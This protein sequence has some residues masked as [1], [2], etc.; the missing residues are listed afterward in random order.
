MKSN[1]I[2]KAQET[3]KRVKAK[4]EEC[5]IS[6]AELARAVGLSRSAICKIEG[7]TNST[8]LDSFKKISKVLNADVMYLLFGEPEDT[9]ISVEKTKLIDQIKELSDRDVA[10]VSA[11]I[12]LIK[13]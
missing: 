12:E 8:S 2:L 6:Q 9:P 1:D 13:E 4:R 11:F 10:K 5:N 7:G 3:G